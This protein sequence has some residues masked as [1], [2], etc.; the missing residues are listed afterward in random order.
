MGNNLAQ[1]DGD[2]RSGEQ[3]RQ[4]MRQMLIRLTTLQRQREEEQKNQSSSVDTAAEVE[5][6]TTRPRRP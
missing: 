5:G 6:E 4:H 1:T 2:G 3:V